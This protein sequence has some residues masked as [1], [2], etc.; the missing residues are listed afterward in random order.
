MLALQN[1][2]VKHNPYRATFGTVQTY[3]Q[4]V[5]AYLRLAFAIS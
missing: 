2:A 3:S 4:M 5:K 1:Y